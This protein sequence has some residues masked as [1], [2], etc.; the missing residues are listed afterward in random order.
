MF[1]GQPTARRRHGA[2][3]C[4]ARRGHRG[5]WP[6]VSVWH[7]DRDATVKPMNADALIAQWTNVHGI[8]AAPVEDKVDGYPR[9]VWRRDGST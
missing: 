5:P 4:G 1:Q 8:E 9:K 2:I 3:W 6:R 7:G